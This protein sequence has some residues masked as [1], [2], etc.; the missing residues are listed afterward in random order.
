MA[1]RPDP[2]AERRMWALLFCSGGVLALIGFF[3]PWWVA[4]GF[5]QTFW[6][7]PGIVLLSWLRP[8]E[9]SVGLPCGEALLLIVLLL[10]EVVMCVTG[11]AAFKL[12]R[13]QQLMQAGLI[14]S[15][16]AAGLGV[17]GLVCAQLGANFDIEFGYPYA[18]PTPFV[19]LGLTFLGLVL[20][21]WSFRALW[22]DYRL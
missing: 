5:G 11:A 17:I 16:T 12:R 6:Y 13:S 7:G 9:E 22:R 19:G 21:L 15:V 8:S 3:V 4:K 14:V 18:T 10:C 1:D 2:A 20:V